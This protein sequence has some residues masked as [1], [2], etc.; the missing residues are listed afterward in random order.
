VSAAVFGAVP[1]ILFKNDTEQP[2]H[3]APCS[4]ITDGAEG[5]AK[6]SSSWPS[7]VVESP[8]AAAEIPHN[9]RKSLRDTFISTSKKAK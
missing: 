8:S 7:S 9:F 5:F 4:Q 2:V 1:D 3:E 6:A